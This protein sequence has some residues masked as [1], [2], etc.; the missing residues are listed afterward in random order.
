MGDSEADVVGRK[1]LEKERHFE[2]RL[3]PT[4]AEKLEYEKKNTDAGRDDR[5]LG[6]CEFDF[7]R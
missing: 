6:M 2:V 5:F 3:S 7:R 1:N 4:R